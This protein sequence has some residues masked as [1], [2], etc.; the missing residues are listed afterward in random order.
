MGGWGEKETFS[1]PA[2]ALAGLKELLERKRRV[3]I[4]GVCRA[5]RGWLAAALVRSGIRPLVW[6]CP[7]EDSAARNAAEAAMFLADPPGNAGQFTSR[8][9]WLPLHLSDPYRQ[10]APDHESE[11]QRLAVLFRL[12]EASPPDALFGSAAAFMHRTM[13]RGELDSASRLLLAGQVIDQQELVEHLLRLGY[14]RVP[15]VEDRGTFAVRGG[16]IDIFP[17]GSELPARIEL[18][19]DE[20]ESMR[21]FDADSQRTVARTDELYIGPSREILWDDAHR[22]KARKN[23]QALASG[24]D[25]TSRQLLET[26]RALRDGRWFVGAE[27]LLPAFYEQPDMP[28]DYLPPGCFVVVEEPAALNDSLRQHWER[29]EEGFS[30]RS[31]D[32]LLYPPGN[33]ALSPEDFEARLRTRAVLSCGLST[34]EDFHATIELDTRPVEGLRKRI[35]QVPPGEDALGPLLEQLDGWRRGGVRT[36]VIGSASRLKELEHLLRRRKV[37]LHVASGSAELPRGLA[38]GAAGAVI[39]AEGTLAGGFV[40]GH[41]AGSTA[42]L[43]DSEI[44]GTR[45]RAAATERLPARKVNLKPG[46]YV[47]HHEFGIARFSRLCRLEAGGALGDFLQLD[48]RGNDRL[49]LPATR[50]GILDRYRSPSGPPPRLSRLGGREWE[51]TKARVRQSLLEMADELL[52]IEARRKTARGPS[53]SPPGEDYEALAASF[54]FE[55]TEDQQVCIKQVIDDLCSPHPMDRL[56]CGDVG[57]GKTE[58]AVRAAYLHA[59]DGRQTAV[60]VP[61][62]ILAFQ[63]IHTFRNRLGPR[64]VRVEMVSRLVPPRRQKEL[65]EELARGSIDVI[66]GTHRLL[67][68]DV[69]FRN[70]GLLVID[71]EQRFGVRHKER[72]KALRQDIDVLTLTATPLPRTM[73]MALSGLRSISVIQP[74]PPGRRS[75]RTIVARFSPKTIKEAIDTE[76]GRGGQVFFLHNWVRSLPAMEK[77]LKRLVPHARIGV[78]HGQ[79]P[80]RRL[81]RVMAD[82]IER[83][84]D[85]LLCTSIIE[86]GLDIPTANTI[87]INRADLF[88]LAQLHQI[89]GRVGRAAE[90]AWAYLLVP[91][92]EAITDQARARLQVLTEHSQLGSGWRIAYEDMELRGAGNLLGTAQSGHI[93]AVGFDLYNRLLERAVAEAR[94]GAEKE[95]PEPELKLP[96]VGLIP[97]DYVPEVEQRLEIYTAMSRAVDEHEVFRQEQRMRD[98]YGPLPPEVETLIELMLLKVRLRRMSVNRAE[99]RG[100]ALEIEFDPGTTID[101]AR[102]VELAESKPDG[103]R[104]RPDGVLEVLPEGGKGA[105]PIEQLNEVLDF[106]EGKRLLRAGAET[107]K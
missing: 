17:P 24:R 34:N 99:A 76:L 19:G 69:R 102:L 70:L 49:Y 107:R 3:H 26:V 82:F 11:M 8:C 50:I 100:E 1:D 43:P 67:Q 5:A 103:I 104:L 81:E 72:L 39:L 21:F 86:S 40:V 54:P 90:R 44:V 57:F 7:D 98:M 64:A 84:I 31:R 38:A 23:L 16:I 105:D 28:F 55:E 29:L 91:G 94:G 93:K 42:Y 97:E 22:Q 46:D 101:S 71:E 79:M 47:V 61:T 12:A 68:P 65:L 52:R 66:I 106:L 36:V 85:V 2:T 95:L 73:Q 10:L 62:T 60:L 56:V 92:T 74:P 32:S 77:F 45:R 89:R 13:P 41:R 83:R 53:A 33:Y 6:I 87:V 48:F 25:V 37:T 30:E 18:L 20:I 59:L 51:R 27:T 75:I 63:H 78:A 80:E 9:E 88:G 96:V 35:E 58:I 14:L 4:A 15:Y